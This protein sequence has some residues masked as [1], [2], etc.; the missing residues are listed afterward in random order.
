ELC[1]DSDLRMGRHYSLLSELAKLNASY[2][3]HENLCAQFM[4]ALYR[5]GQQWR[6]IEGYRKLRETLVSELG[7]GPPARMQ[8]VQRGDPRS[9]PV[10][11]EPPVKELLRERLTI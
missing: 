9:D 8:A 5:A 3:M 10:L 2:P 7:V 4:V 6:A 11:N 1:I